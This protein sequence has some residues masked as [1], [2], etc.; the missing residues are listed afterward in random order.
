MGEFYKD[1]GLQLSHPKNKEHYKAYL[2]KSGKGKTNVYFLRYLTLTPPPFLAIPSHIPDITV[3]GKE[4][5][6]T[7]MAE[8]NK[9]DP[10]IFLAIQK[11][12][13]RLCKSVKIQAIHKFSIP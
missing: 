11:L 1:F 2:A 7:M 8:T 10:N 9:L 4:L 13:G 6:T 5:F 3:D 12:K